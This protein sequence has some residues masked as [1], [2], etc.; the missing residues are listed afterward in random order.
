M[1]LL[2]D[3]IFGKILFKAELLPLLQTLLLTLL[4]GSLLRL[5]N[6]W[7][8]LGLNPLLLVIP[9]FTADRFPGWPFN[10]SDEINEGFLPRSGWVGNASGSTYVYSAPFVMVLL[11][12][13]W[14]KIEEELDRKRYLGCIKF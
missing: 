12:L 13:L 1:L 9:E 11:F 4:E 3:P 14:G 6:C 7:N 5:G 10:I 8:W 2:L